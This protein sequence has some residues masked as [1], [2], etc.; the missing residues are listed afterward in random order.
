M[1]I[2]PGRIQDLPVYRSD[3]KPFLLGD[4]HTNIPVARGE[5]LQEPDE[6]GTVRVF[7]HFNE[8]REL[9]ATFKLPSI[10]VGGAGSF[11]IKNVTD[12]GAFIDIG[13][14][15]DI[16]IPHREQRVPLEEGRMT[17]VTLQC[18]LGH[19]RLFGSTRF[20][21]FFQNKEHHLKRGDE[22][23]MVIAERLEA[24]R[25]VIVNG[26]YLAILFRQEMVRNV[27]EGERLK[28][29]IRKIE[30]KD[31]VVSMQKEGE[32]LIDD[33]VKRLLE[34]LAHHNGYIRLN[35]NS[36]PEEIKL[37]LRMSKKTFKK[38][39]GQLYKERKVDLTRFGVKL[40][41]TGEEALIPEKKRRK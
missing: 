19:R 39:V 5:R 13:T 28:G 29:Y 34:F 27:H 36:D 31:I 38:A 40:I 32:E 37:R 16:L 30:G 41:K 21:H 33:A 3:E 6:K 26:A 7:V 11:R 12:A 4:E 8:D 9:E 22:V 14:R 20:T 2:E 15:R 23:D 35:D 1:R 17:L 18:D 10:E 24:G 25:R